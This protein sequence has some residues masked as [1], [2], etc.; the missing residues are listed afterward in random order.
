MD[1]EF[2]SP[3]SAAERGVLDFLLGAEFP[4]VEALRHQALHAEVTGLCGCGCPSFG[5][6][7]DESLAVGAETN[8]KTPVDVE[9]R[10]RS[11]DP[12]YELLLIT[13]DGWLSYVELVTY[14]G[15]LAPSAFP[16]MSLFG[17]P[18]QYG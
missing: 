12:P 2:P 11:S 13:R 17:P 16:P 6:S 9:A 18:K 7:I 10:S 8:P 15:E 5:L 14:G 4:G 1:S 3:M